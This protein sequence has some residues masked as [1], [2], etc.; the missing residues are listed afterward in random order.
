MKIAIL[1]NYDSF[2][3]NLKQYVDTL[4]PC[5][6]EI[7]RN[8]AHEVEY[9]KQ[10]DRIIISPGPG[11]PDEAG[12]CLE[13]IEAYSGK[14]P[15][16]GV[17]LGM[18]AIA[19]AFGGKLNNLSRVYHGVA[20]RVDVINDFSPLFKGIPEQFEAGRYHSWVV[21][22]KSLPGALKP[23]ALDPDNMLMAIA[24]ISHPTYGVQFHPE[25][26]LTPVGKDIL[27]NF[28]TCEKDK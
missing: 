20:T 3:Y 12:M 11:L 17:C 19:E 6:T 23:I 4:L 10:F 15:I 9:F 22:R 14:I 8:D 13:L 16:L 2:T 24:H 7:I 27:R 26:I 18:Q 1:D 25:S 28:L 5:T 21:E